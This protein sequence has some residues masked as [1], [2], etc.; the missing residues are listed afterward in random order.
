MIRVLIADDHA[1]VRSG[2]RLICEGAA[3]ITVV[4]ETGDGQTTVDEARRL[5][6]DVVLMDIRMPRMDGIAATRALA[7]ECDVVILTTYGSPQHLFEALAAG[8][9]GFLLKDTD[10]ETLLSALR[11][12]AAGDGLISPAMTRT[13]IA[14]FSRLRPTAP[15]VDDSTLTP[16]ERQVWLLIGRGL[17]NAQIASELDMA[18][19]T[20]K[21]H[22]SRVLSKLGLRSRVQAAIAAG[23]VES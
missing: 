12:V 1:A 6:P 7:G 10:A 4:G 17:T 21:T 15:T 23:G 14:E 9:A 20:V 22:V 11:L 19:G 8:A 13:L 3:D 5:A 18:E 2:L 16:R